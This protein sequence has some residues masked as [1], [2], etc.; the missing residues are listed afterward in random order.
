MASLV[1]DDLCRS[2][3]LLSGKRNFPAVVLQNILGLFSTLYTSFGPAL[4][5]LIECFTMYVFLKSLHQMTAMLETQVISDVYIYYLF[6][7]FLTLR[8]K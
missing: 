7:Y 4:K 3:L 5:V 2:L 6:I 8:L 1:R